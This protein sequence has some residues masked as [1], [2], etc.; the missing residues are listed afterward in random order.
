MEIENS[1]ALNKAFDLLSRRAHS[2]KELRDKLYKREYTKRE[3]EK[4]VAECDR[5]GLL[6]DELFAADYASELAGQ[7]KG[8]YVIKMK[9]RKK[10]L[11]EQHIEQAL[12]KLGDCELENAEYALQRKMSSLINEPDINKRRQKAYR[13]LA[14]RGFS[15]DIINQLMDKIPELRYY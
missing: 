7:G 15:V 2:T 9:L 13:F 1:E 12:E 3:I 6:N 11:A 8:A 10:G 5:M 14:Y 4:A